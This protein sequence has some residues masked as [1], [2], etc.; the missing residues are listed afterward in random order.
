MRVAWNDP[1][2]CHSFQDSTQTSLL[3][4]K[5]TYQAILM[6]DCILKNGAILPQAKEDQAAKTR[7]RGLHNIHP[8]LHHDHVLQQ[9][10]RH[11]HG[12]SAHDQAIHEQ[13]HSGAQE[14]QDWQDLLARLQPVLVEAV[15]QGWP[16]HR[17]RDAW[18]QVRVARD[19]EASGLGQLSG[20]WQHLDQIPHRGSYGNFHRFS[21]WR[22]GSTPQR[23]L[24]KIYITN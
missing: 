18:N 22:R 1:Q 14:T 15:G 13:A 3:Q 2:I 20:Q 7:G 11:Q 24:I 8:L 16:Q 6:I 5:E 10:L 17:V 12:H 4:A 9:A 19:H 21:L 23:W